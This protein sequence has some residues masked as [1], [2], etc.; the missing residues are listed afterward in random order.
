[1][2]HVAARA[3]R[4]WRQRNELHQL[5]EQMRQAQ[6]LEAVGRLTSGIA[7]DFNNMLMGIIGCADIALGQLEPGS[8]PRNYVEEIRD[9]ALRGA[10][11]TRQ[12]LAFG[13][14]R[15]GERGSCTPSEVIG[16]AAPM[17]E[18]A[19]DDNV[20]LEVELNAPSDVVVG[21]SAGSL[22]QVL[23]N[24]VINASDAIAGAG[25]IRVT[26]SL[27]DE[28]GGVGR[29][30]EHPC[31]VLEITDDGAGIPSEVQS[32]IFEPFY[33][34]KGLD[35]GTGLGLSTVYGICT[36]AGGDI[37]VESTLGEGTTFTVQLPVVDAVA[38]E[39]S[40]GTPSEAGATAARGLHRVLVVEDESLVRLSVHKYLV[41]AGYDVTAVA[42]GRE[43]IDRHAEAG[44]DLVVTDMMLPGAPG[45]EVASA[46]RRQDPDVGVLYMSAHP[47]E[48]LVEKGALDPGEGS[49]VKP[50][51]REELLAAVTATLAAFA[52]PPEGAVL[53]VDDHRATRLAMEALLAE[54]GFEVATA[55]DGAAAWERFTDPELSVG[56]VITDVGL[57]D[58]SGAEL[59]ERIKGHAPQTRVIIISGRAAD[60]PDLRHL[61]ALDGVVFLQKPVDFDALK[62]LVGGQ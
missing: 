47:T 39:T 51:S 16:K 35:E 30:V 44:F 4:E 1:M 13:R 23:M 61:A 40:A 62:A 34:T 8:S 50:F 5:E 52:A 46:F 53:V 37:A 20:V 2:P 26:T 10:S 59:V 45:R 56:L 24:L 33:T 6:K 36:Q 31:W 55:A 18:P 43:A 42:S 41:E 19:I 9:A 32:Q 49:L 12:L 11:L 54:D 7:H 27:R 21:V 28:A 58:I 14:K 22:E 3:L 38:D 57:P 17:L 48:F 25:H 29:H 60:D 15:T